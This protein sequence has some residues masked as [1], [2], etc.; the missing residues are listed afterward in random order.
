MIP[1]FFSSAQM[2]L[3]ECHESPANLEGLHS[4]SPLSKPPPPL[5]QKMRMVLSVDFG[6]LQTNEFGPLIEITRIQLEV[7]SCPSW[8]GE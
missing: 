4:L 1:M 8:D 7:C 2:I 3:L 5:L 6:S